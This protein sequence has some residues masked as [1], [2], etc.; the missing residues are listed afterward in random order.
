MVQWPYPESC[1]Y[2]T[3]RRSDLGKKCAPQDWDR[4]LVSKFEAILYIDKQQG[5]YDTSAKMFRLSKMMGVCDMGI[6]GRSFG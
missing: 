1:V 3:V 6:I 2:A 5:S 4:N